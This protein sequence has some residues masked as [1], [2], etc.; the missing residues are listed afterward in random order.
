MNA[1]K[2]DEKITIDGKIEESVWEK[3]EI[4]TD[5][6]SYSP[7]NGKP[8]DKVKNTE[9]RIIYNNDAL[10][11][12]AI[13]YDNEPEKIL[14]QITKRDASGIYDNFGVFI[15][16]FND[17]QQDF[18]FYVSASGV[19][20][21]CIS[22]IDAF[23]DFTWNA[24]WD[25]QARITDFGWVV[26]MKIPY[27]A[28]RF[29]SNNLQTWGIN[30]YREVRRARQSYTWNYINNN[31]TN[32]NIQAGL[33]QGIENINT[34]TRLF[35][36]PYASYYLSNAETEKPKG[37][38]KGGL[39]IKYGITDAFTL[40][41]ILIPDF[42]QTKFDNVILNL[43]PFEQ[44]FNENRP[45]F[46]EGIDLF[47]KDKLVYTRRIGG[48]PSYY[49]ELDEN[50]TIYDYPSTV[51]VTNALKFSGRTNGNLGIGVLNAVT[52]ET[53]AEITNTETNETR[54]E[55]VEPIANYNVLVLDQRI[56][57]NS[58][59][60]FVNTNVIRDGEF[61]DANVS[62]IIFNLNT[63]EN[64]FNID[65]NF[66]YSFVNE[67]G[68][69]GENQG[70]DTK[71]G[72]SKTKGK[73]RASIGGQYVS[74]D[75]DCNDLGI[76]FITHYSSF[77]G[78]ISY[79]ILEPTKTFNKFETKLGYYS[80]FDND[81][82]YIQK[83]ELSLNTFAYN[84]KN[85]SYSFNI[86][87]RPTEIY[88]FYEP[89]SEDQSTYFIEPKYIGAT[90]NYSSNYNRK[91]AID[92][93]PNYRIYDQEDREN[94]GFVVSPRYRFNDHLTANLDFDFYRQNNNIGRIELDE[95]DATNEDIFARRNIVTYINTL[96][97]KYAIN[98]AMNISLAVRHYWSYTTN[99]Q[100]YNLLED[101]T[102]EENNDY[103]ENNDIN[104]NSW[105]FDLS[106]SWWF[107]PGSEM[108]ILYRNNSLVQ[109]NEDNPDYIENTKDILNWETLDQVFSIS[110]RYHIDYNSF[111]KK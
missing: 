66:N 21:D 95:F 46:T 103:T 44:E 30:F 43:T 3:A 20:A 57:D 54:E 9:V 73:F 77:F 45:F 40:D 59:V 22:N 49:P 111:K 92:I 52:Q 87:C 6:I 71:L 110:I 7:D 97:G 64:T 23:E 16:G 51:N 26:E 82:G 35:F 65:G 83:N 55:V 96:N 70:F 98:N 12:A 80:E 34:P 4:A 94:Y 76:N 56:R 84:L 37:E 58:S 63:K 1:L 27:A 93:I 15:N 74:E 60:S 67:Y 5:F 17:G 109:D 72:F 11:I 18:R 36:N 91:F 108:F 28:L 85:D 31:I 62:A 90:F 32:E 50:E 81:T 102:I 14:K 53:K 13:M 61:R 29:P 69:E 88:N 79:R 86:L 89:G 101:G 48:A 38:F 100:Y 68:N 104:F 24:V 10:Y 8:A 75:Y 106:Y 107:A 105:N 47:T 39:D 99:L 33:L 41:A 19:Q 42:G 2:T 78:N 25:S